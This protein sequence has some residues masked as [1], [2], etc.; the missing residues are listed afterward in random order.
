MDSLF[1]FLYPISLPTASY[2]G[3]PWAYSYIWSGGD[4]LL[5][6]LTH[7]FAFHETLLI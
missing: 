7:N 1:L 3:P 5:H 6:S 4:S 2:L